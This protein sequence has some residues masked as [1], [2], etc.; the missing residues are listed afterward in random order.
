SAPIRS[1]H[2]T[3]P[4]TNAPT[5]C[6]PTTTVCSTTCSH[7]CTARSPTE[8]AVVYSSEF[9]GGLRCHCC[10]PWRHHQPPQPQ[11]SPPRPR[12]PAP[13]R[14]RPPTPQGPRRFSISPTMTPST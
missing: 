9:V 11:R 13:R 2:P 7:T 14:S 8:V 4:P 3:E 12:R 10:D 1:S 6:P 5:N